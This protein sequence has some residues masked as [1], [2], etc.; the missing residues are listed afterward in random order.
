[1]SWQQ[2]FVAVFSALGFELEAVASADFTLFSFKGYPLL[3]NLIALDAPPAAGTL[4]VLQERYDW[5]GLYCVQLW[6]DIWLQRSAQVVGRISSILG[7]NQRIHARKTKLIS[8]SQDEADLFLN[9]NHLQGSVKARYKY[10]LTENGQLVAV[11]TFS[12]LR[13]MRERAEGH[14]SAELIRF[15]AL[16]GYTVVGGFT[17]IL[18]HF[19]SLHHP[20]DIMSYADRDWSL[21]HAYVHSGFKFVETT[22]PL[23]IWLDQRTMQRHFPHRLSV[24]DKAQGNYTMIHNTGNLKYRLYLPHV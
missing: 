11:A 6:E 9:V 17:K 4:I 20:D 16:S 1:M 3:V 23:E 18:Q 21:G 2:D 13:L 12:N 22:P 15:A 19:I 10:A 14:R 7:K 24:E 8:L 5:E